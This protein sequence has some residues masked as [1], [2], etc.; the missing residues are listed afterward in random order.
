MPSDGMS[1]TEGAADNGE[2]AAMRRRAATHRST[3]S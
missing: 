1:A 3:S 2:A